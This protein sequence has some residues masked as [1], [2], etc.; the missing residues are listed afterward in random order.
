MGAETGNT[1]ENIMSFSVNM[2]WEELKAN[3]EPIQKIMETQ[4]MPITCQDY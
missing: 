2:P 3:T 1:F 4:M